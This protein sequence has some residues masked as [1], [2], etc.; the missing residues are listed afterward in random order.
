MFSQAGIGFKSLPCASH[1]GIS[2]FLRSAFLTVMAYSRY[3]KPDHTA[4]TF[5]V[6]TREGWR[7]ARKTKLRLYSYSPLGSSLWEP[8]QLRHSMLVQLRGARARREG[9]S[10]PS[11]L[12]SKKKWTTMFSFKRKKSFNSLLLE[13]S[14][15]KN[16]LKL[17]Y[18]TR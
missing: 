16:I 3:S 18:Q 9:S 15:E 17:I 2:E 7:R 8:R 11:I 4:Q 1:P 13:M 10:L 6:R 14:G 12:K 5:V